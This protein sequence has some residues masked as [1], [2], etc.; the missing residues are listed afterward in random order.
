[1]NLKRYS[2][3]A[4]SLVIVF[5]LVFLADWNLVIQKIGNTNIYLYISALIVFLSSYIPRTVRWTNLSGSIGY[6]LDLKDAFRMLAVSYGFNQMLPGNTGD[7]ARS[8]IFERYSPVE[9]HSSILGI[10]GLERLLDAASILFFLGISAIIVGKGIM[11]QLYWV[12]IPFSI[13]VIGTSFVL[14]YWHRPFEVLKNLLPGRFPDLLDGFLEAYKKQ[15]RKDITVNFGLS[16]SSW[17]TE[18]VAFYIVILS[19]GVDVAFW[20]GAIVTHTMSLVSS[21]PTSPGGIGFGDAA[22]TGIL[23]FTGLAYSP[24]LSLIILQRALGIV[25]T[26]FLGGIVYWSEELL[27]L[28]SS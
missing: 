28:S 21:L 10:T 24:A 17:F 18:A 27:S 19:L 20:E 14:L 13:G 8:K 1:M 25:F 5:A 3:L 23:T 12:I 6:D 2:S 15:S 4:V 7:L 11:G 16:L 26:A 9:K 22:G